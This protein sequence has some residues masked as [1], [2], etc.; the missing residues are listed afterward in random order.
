MILYA[1]CDAFGELK[2][3]N[4]V[5]GTTLSGWGVV[6]GNPWTFAGIFPSKEAAQAK[7]DELGEGYEVHWG[8][9]REGTDDFVWSGTTPCA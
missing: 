6:R 9:N 4:Y 3:G 8:D 7:A 5:D 1:D 2:M